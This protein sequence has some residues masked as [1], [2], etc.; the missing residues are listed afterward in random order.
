MSEVSEVSENEKVEEGREATNRK[1][2]ED[3][4]DL[5]IKNVWCIPCTRLNNMIIDQNEN[6]NNYELIQSVIKKFNLIWLMLLSQC[7]W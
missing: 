6:L 4:W 2:P 1:Y 5:L 3:Y 7:C